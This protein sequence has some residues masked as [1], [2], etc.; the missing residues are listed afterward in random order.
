VSVRRYAWPLKYAR[1]IL[2]DD[3]PARK[4]AIQ[5]GLPVIGTAGVL[6]LAKE[7]HLIAVVGPSLDALIENRFFLGPA[8]YE[9]ILKRVGEM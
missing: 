5:L 4:L 9:L 6:V 8:L 2:L 3:D 7:R 1:A